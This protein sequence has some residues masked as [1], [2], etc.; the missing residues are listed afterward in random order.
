MLRRIVLV[1]LLVGFAMP[2]LM[3]A[4]KPTLARPFVPSQRIIGVG[5]DR[6][7][8]TADQLKNRTEVMARAQ[9][10]NIMKHRQYW[11]SPKLI[12]ETRLWDIIQSAAKAQGLDPMRL[13]ARIFLESAGDCNARSSD[14][15]GCAQFTISGGIDAGLVKTERK[16]VRGRWVRVV[17]RDDRLNPTLAIPAMARRIKRQTDVYGRPDFEIAEYH[18]GYGNML[19]AVSLS[20]GVHL[21]PKRT[22]I[23]AVR[24]LIADRSLSYPLVYFGN[25][26]RYKPE[27]YRFLRSLDDGSRTY[28]FRVEAASQLLAIYR[29]SKKD[30]EEIVRANQPK[31]DGQ[32]ELTKRMWSFYGPSDV[33]KYGVPDLA[34]LIQAW[35]NGRN[36]RVVAMPNLPDVFGIRIRTS[37]MSPIGELTVNPKSRL[38]NPANQHW[39]IGS[40]PATLG[41][42]LYV[43]FELRRLEGASFGVVETNSLGRDLVYQRV[44]GGSKPLAGT[45]LPTHGMQKA[46]DL[47]RKNMAASQQSELVFLLDDLESLGLLSWIPEGAAGQ[48]AYHVVPD[49]WEWNRKFF[50]NIY[51]DAKAFMR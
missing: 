32:N 46:F 47:P 24:Q 6:E 10:F 26:N 16:R 45:Q 11:D 3:V 13:A 38:Y 2:S 7:S 44:L 9:W 18:M 48:F 28:Y 34:A 20:T 31:F 27:L 43:G 17:T 14:A 29:H 49:P 40:E 33:A 23:T 22:P 42:L 37:G 19:K 5:K 1:A 12:F 4:Q 39:Y 8:L 21:D 41:C 50:E 30:Y 25:T 51:K 15:V 36:G 35:G